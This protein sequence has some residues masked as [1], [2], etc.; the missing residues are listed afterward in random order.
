M[1][2][3]ALLKIFVL[4]GTGAQG[5]PK[6]ESLVSDGKYSCRI[7]NP[8]APFKRSRSLKDLGTNVELVEGTFTN[9][10]IYAK[11]TAAVMLLS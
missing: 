10:L 8:D 5:L 9:E 1:S 2:H 7:L 3:P 4:G 11:F 6:V